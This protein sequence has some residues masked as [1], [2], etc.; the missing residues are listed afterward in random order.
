M[1]RYGHL[2]DKIITF[3]NMYESYLEARKGRKLKPEIL[4][5][6]R[7]IE[8]TIRE[9]QRQLHDG[10]WRSDRYNEFVCYTEVKRRVIH[11]PSFR[12]R[13]FHH[14]LVRIV[15]PLFE[16]KFIYDSYA[17][18]KGRGVHPA[19]Y[20]TQ[21]FLRRASRQGERVYVLQCDISKYYPSMD[22]EFLKQRIR[23]TIADERVLQAW[24]ALIDGFEI[25]PGKGLPIGALTSQISANIYLDYLDHYIKDRLRIKYY[26]RYMDDFIVI[27]NSKAELQELLG[28]IRRVVMEEMKLKLNPKTRI[29][30]ASKGVNF[31]GY[32]I[33]TTHILP[34]KRNVKAARIRFRRLNHE[35]KYYRASLADVRS[36]VM[37]FL[38]YMKHCQGSKTTKSTLKW[39][40]LRR[41][42][43]CQEQH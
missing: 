4:K 11:A 43:N 38:G 24:D 30:A 40:K 41:N 33:F 37:S 27:G 14:A 7:N 16:R 15:R 22:H 8:K 12:N 36:R 9:M 31:A 32:R 3:E 6:G 2:F 34:R 29:Y 10:T 28:K 19:V 25:E 5:A 18:I 35:Y 42:E 1:E 23:R 20:R 39:I 21:D 26:L 17:I 13:I